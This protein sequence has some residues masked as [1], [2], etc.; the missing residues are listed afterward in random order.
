[1]PLSKIQDI[2][3]Q[4]I[5][6]LGR[7]NIV[8]NGGMQ[9]AQRGT[10]S[11][12]TGYCSLDRYPIYPNNMDEL[13]YTWAQDS[14]VPTGEGFSKSAK[15]TVTTAESAL[16]ADEIL[17]IL[18]RIEGQNMQ[19]A[20]WG[21]SGAKPLTL[22]FYVRSNVTGTY[23][24]EFRMNNGG[25]NSLSK[26]YTISAANTWERKT[27]TFPANTST[28]FNNN[29]TNACELGWYLAAGT[30]Y[31][32]GSLASDYGANATNTRA[33]GQTANVASTNSNT[34]YITGIQL[35]VGDTATDFEHRSF[36]EELILC[37]RYCRGFTGLNF[38]RARDGDSFYGGGIIF[39]PPMRATPTLKSGATYVV[40]TGNAGT[41]AVNSG[42][43]PNGDGVQMYNSAANWTANAF[44]RLTAIFE[45]E[46]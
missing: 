41:P 45:A 2:E 31:T 17:R 16:A 39:N 4:V 28:N 30:N 38:G 36:G 32:S 42:F 43:N 34:W 15:L 33:A 9:V 6:D 5:P 7:R 21:T 29:N 22:S 3:N 12:S 35:E 18:H 8:I 20:S 13:A 46:L 26:T 24:V 37:Q 27:I 40:N 10:S 25:S 14:T 1:M 19:Q 44:P 23:A 11:T